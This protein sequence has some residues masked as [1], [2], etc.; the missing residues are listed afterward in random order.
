AAPARK[1]AAPSLGAPALMIAQAG[2]EGGAEEL[3]VEV[4]RRIM[5]WGVK[6]PCALRHRFRAKTH[7]LSEQQN[8]R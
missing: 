4:S 7:S 3:A 5:I 6:R 1:A 2:T 8:E